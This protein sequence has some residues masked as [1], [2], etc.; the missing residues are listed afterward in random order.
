MTIAASN[1]SFNRLNIELGRISTSTLSINDSSVSGFLLNGA[2]SNQSL[3]S[4]VGSGTNGAAWQDLWFQPVKTDIAYLASASTYCMVTAS[5]Y[6]LISTDNCTT[7]TRVDLT[8]FPGAASGFNA[9]TAIPGVG[10]VAC[11]KL[12]SGGIFKS[13][14]GIT[15]STATNPAPVA[16]VCVAYGNGNLVAAG[17]GY[18]SGDIGYHIY[19]TNNGLTW[20]MTN[21]NARSNWKPVS[22]A[23]NGAGTW[24]A[25][26]PGLD[27]GFHVCL[28]TSTNNGV[29][30]SSTVVGQNFNFDKVA[31]ASNLGLW[32]I[33]PQQGYTGISTSTN[34]TSWTYTEVASPYSPVSLTTDGYSFYSSGYYSGVY[35]TSQFTSSSTF[36]TKETFPYNGGGRYLKA[37][38]KKGEVFDIGG[39]GH[40]GYRSTNTATSFQ[41][42]TQVPEIQFGSAASNGSLVA[43]VNNSNDNTTVTKGIFTSPD[44]LTW[45]QRVS[46]DNMLCVTWT[47]SYWVAAG[48]ANW[49]MTS[50]DG[51]TWTQKTFSPGGLYN[52]FKAFGVGSK[53]FA[54]ETQGTPAISLAYSTDSGVTWTTSTGVLQTAFSYQNP[55]T[56]KSSV[57]AMAY[58]GTNYVAVGS[59]STVCYSSDGISWSSTTAPWSS[60]SD[61][62]WNGTRFIGVSDYTP[63]ASNYGIVSQDGIT[64]TLTTLPGGNVFQSVSSAT[65]GRV[66]A[67]AYSNGIYYG[68]ST[69]STWTSVITFDKTSDVTGI[70]SFNL[71]NLGN[72]TVALTGNNRVMISPP[73]GNQQVF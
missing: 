2:V 45:T 7:Y 13:A 70:L 32:V 73:N 69:G 72:S 10:F 4:M 48:A 49:I 21:I 18:S 8:S 41:Q 54:F 5:P 43:A 12:A 1:I 26:G 31:Y 6:V 44:G 60:I 11:P 30:W 22:I 33:A 37:S 20:S 51:V 61:V 29:T 28:Y 68:N 53:M 36:V 58:N 62:T 71:V 25:A 17:R 52:F 56:G 9:I 24:V 19:S 47:G 59:T 15:W 42:I 57:Q 67:S 34:G 63:G 23:T 38:S 64:W 27:A 3:N 50:P 46:N 40:L 14:D 55:F 16:M 66:V 35:V 39:R 65:S